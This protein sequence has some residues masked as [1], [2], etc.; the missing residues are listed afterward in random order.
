MG[1]SYPGKFMKSF[2]VLIFKT[3]LI[4]SIYQHTYCTS[5]CFNQN[6]LLVLFIKV[7]FGIKHHSFGEQFF[8]IICQEN[9][10]VKGHDTKVYFNT[11]LRITNSWAIKDCSLSK[12]NHSSKHN[13][14]PF[15]MGQYVSCYSSQT[16]KH[17]KTSLRQ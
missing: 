15:L 5:Q 9:N 14:E 16:T 17:L 6:P 4:S 3:P 7:I 12:P 11:G 1:D 10:R 13:G 8:Q 2:F